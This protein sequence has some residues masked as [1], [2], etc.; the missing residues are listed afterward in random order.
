MTDELYILRLLDLCS[1]ALQVVTNRAL[2]I[3]YEAKQKLFHSQARVTVNRLMVSSQQQLH[4]SERIEEK[5][6]STS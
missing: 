2:A 4:H 1:I 5:L 3:S 6:E